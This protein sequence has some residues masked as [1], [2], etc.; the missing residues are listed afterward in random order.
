VRR[1]ASEAKTCTISI[2]IYISIRLYEDDDDD[3]AAPLPR[4]RYQN[5]THIIVN[6]PIYIYIYT[7][8]I[9]SSV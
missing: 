9:Q 6:R 3:D 7:S 2:Y 4:A 5:S 1:E 8:I